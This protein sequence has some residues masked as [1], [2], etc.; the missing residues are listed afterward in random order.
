VHISN[1][2]HPWFS[3]VCDGSP[4]PPHQA[5][6]K[7]QG[8]P[9]FSLPL[10]QECTNVMCKNRDM[11]CA[12]QDRWCCILILS[13]SWWAKPPGGKTCGE[14]SRSTTSGWFVRQYGTLP[15]FCQDIPYHWYVT[16]VLN[17]PFSLWKFPIV[18]WL[19][20]RIAFERQCFS[21][22]TDVLHNL[23]SFC[24]CLTVM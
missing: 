17:A 23:H 20:L 9:L 18:L 21:I 11:E 14:T 12:L 13:R 2:R 7:I 8:F 6:T 24:S 3:S 10:W 22:I 15:L 5:K 1:E 19:M 16:L 4:F